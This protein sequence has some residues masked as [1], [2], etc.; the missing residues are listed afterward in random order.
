MPHVQSIQNSMCVPDL[1]VN[2]DVYMLHVCVHTVDFN[3]TTRLRK[4]AIA[5]AEK[6]GAKKEVKTKRAGN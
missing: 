6:P 4:M 3:I 5:Q 1:G 2:C